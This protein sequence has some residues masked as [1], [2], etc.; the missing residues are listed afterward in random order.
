MQTTFCKV[1]D[2]DYLQRDTFS[3]FSFATRSTVTA[4][5]R[6]TLRVF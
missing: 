4:D 6:N 2:R 5:C 3:I 1:N